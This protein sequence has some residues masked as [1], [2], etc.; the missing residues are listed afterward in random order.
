MSFQLTSPMRTWGAVTEIR[1]G[2]IE[3]SGV[4]H[5]VGI[6]D[7]VTIEKPGQALIGEVMSVTDK[8]VDILM[9]SSTEAVRIGDRAYV[10]QQD[11]VSIGDHWR[12]ALINYRGEAQLRRTPDLTA[13]QTMRVPLI[14]V[15]PWVSSTL[16]G[17]TTSSR[18]RV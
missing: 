11:E 14:V 4:S 8:G 17:I 2:M 15:G 10:S 16:P 5:A 3:L 1:P 12:G 7:S 9:F 18:A 6:G 13:R